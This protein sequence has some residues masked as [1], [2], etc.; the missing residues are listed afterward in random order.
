M[1]VLTITNRKKPTVFTP[2]VVSPPTIQPQNL[3][4]VT[5]LAIY[6]EAK[7]RNAIIKELVK[8]FNY[9]VGDVV[10]CSNPQD[11]TKWGSCTILS[12][13]DDYQHM[14]KDHK[15]PGNDNPMIVTASSASGEIFFA[16]TNYFKDG[17]NDSTQTS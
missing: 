6:N 11:Q 13:L 3:P 1:I 14:E 4:Y 2:A 9:K 5:N 8:T 17:V 16:T 12:V 7:R 15:W 10:D